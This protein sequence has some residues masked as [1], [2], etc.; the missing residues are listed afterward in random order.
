MPHARLIRRDELDVADPDAVRRFDFGNAD[1]VLNAAAYTAVDAA[2]TDVA[3]AWATNATALSALARAALR[4]RF[5]LVHYSTDY[6]F[7]GTGG[8]GLDGGYRESDPIAPINV[9]GQSKAAGELA[10]ASVPKHYLIRTSWVVGDGQNF[11]STMRRLARSGVSPRVVSDQVG[12]LTFATELVRATV[13]LLD[14]GAD[15]GTY[16]VTNGG[17]PASWAD[18]AARVFAAEGRDPTDVVAVSTAEYL[19]DHKGPVAPRPAW[20][21]LELG[22]I[23]ATGFRPVGQVQGLADLLAQSVTNKTSTQ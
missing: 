11:V 13:H 12:R 23:E 2:E 3:A 15:P 18:I 19:A 17:A 9:Y 22:R 4:H 21:V 20:S 14:S 1:T 6:V 10:V 7:D 8:S 5:T 16:H